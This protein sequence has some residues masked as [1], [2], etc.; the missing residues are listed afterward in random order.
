MTARHLESFRGA[1]FFI[2]SEHS[3]ILVENRWKR[4]S[5]E[6]NHRWV[7]PRPR[8]SARYIFQISRLCVSSSVSLLRRLESSPITRSTLQLYKAKGYQPIYRSIF[9]TLYGGG[10]RGVNRFSAWSTLA[11]SRARVALITPIHH[12]RARGV[13][14]RAQP[15]FDTRISTIARVLG[16]SVRGPRRWGDAR[17]R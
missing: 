12:N 3:G 16:G 6:M 1:V 11:C 17:R 4:A 15:R 14:A 13:S 5:R 10:L 2:S 8:T 7:I 9:A